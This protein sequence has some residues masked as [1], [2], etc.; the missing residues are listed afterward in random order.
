MCIAYNSTANLPGGTSGFRPPEYHLMGIALDNNEVGWPPKLFTNIYDF[1]WSNGLV[2][3]AHGGEEGPPEYIWECIENLMVIRIDHGIRSIEDPELVSYM[4]TPQ[5]NKE[6]NRAYNQSHK[7]P[8]TVC[9]LSNNKL[10]VFTDP[11][12]TN[13][14]EMLDL[15]IMV[16]VNSDDPAYFGGYVTENY[17]FLVEY[18]SKFNKFRSLQLSDIRNLCINGFE[19]SVLPLRKKLSYISEVNNYFINSPG[20]LYKNLTSNL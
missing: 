11:K 18:L 3:V 7:L 15:G 4:A 2:N 6:M 17:L 13:I 1:A 5:N 16:T 12:D 19:A 14:L 9:P 8:V 20:M 10:K